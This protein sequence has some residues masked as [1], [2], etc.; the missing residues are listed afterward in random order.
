MHPSSVRRRA[1]L[2]GVAVT[3][4]AAALARVAAG[5]ATGLVRAPAVDFAGLLVQLCALA[6]LVATAL[7]WAT[8]CATVTGQLRRPGVPRRP[9]GPVR[10][11]LLAAC[12]VVVLAAPATA[13]ADPAPAPSRP[14]SLPTS[15]AGLP[16][17]D[18]PTGAAESARTV[19]VRPGDSLWAISARTLGPAAR[20]DEV[21]SYGR[22]V[23]V[24]NA[25]VI[26]P[27]PDL[28]RP[29]QRLRLPPTEDA[30]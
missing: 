28:V 25:R 13:G 2:L 21:A 26:G 20:A 24:L 5:P 16:Y 22:Q 23:H 30:R 7:L 17:P 12:G 19:V 27:D 4:G 29:G 3:V 10:A 18:R 11:L 8:T 9:V 15:L 14:T 6:A 1:A